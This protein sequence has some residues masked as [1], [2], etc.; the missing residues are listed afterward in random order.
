M[1][2]VEEDREL[3]NGTK[4]FLSAARQNISLVKE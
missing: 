3:S 1:V 4:A 2:R